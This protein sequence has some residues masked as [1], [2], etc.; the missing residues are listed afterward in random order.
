MYV[1]LVE[2]ECI[3]DDEYIFVGRNAKASK[4]DDYNGSVH[5]LAIFLK[6]KIVQITRDCFCGNQPNLR[7]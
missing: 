3:A 1:V 2:T 7:C 4:I 5:F 6:Y